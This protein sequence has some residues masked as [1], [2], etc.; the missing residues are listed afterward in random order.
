MYANKSE[1]ERNMLLKINEAEYNDFS[2]KKKFT[3]TIHISG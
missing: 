3:Y 1:K 2:I